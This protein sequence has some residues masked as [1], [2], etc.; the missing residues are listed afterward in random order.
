[1]VSE[2]DSNKKKVH[3]GDK[4][5]IEISDRV[6]EY[7]EKKEYEQG[8]KEIAVDIVEKI[9][10]GIVPFQEILDAVILDT[11]REAPNID[12]EQL[13]MRVREK[14]IEVTTYDKNS[15]MNR[16]FKK[17]NITPK[18]LG[19]MLDEYGTDILYIGKILRERELEEEL[20]QILE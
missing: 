18:T 17:F 15:E 3:K 9:V 12:D 14:L 2:M 19:E 10:N 16:L 4:M 6:R 20:G 5:V 8:I 11:L 13:H 1:M 7:A